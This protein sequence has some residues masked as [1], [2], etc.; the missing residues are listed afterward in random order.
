MALYIMTTKAVL[1]IAKVHQAASM[2]HIE[3]RLNSKGL[4]I[5][6]DEPQEEAGFYPRVQ[7][8]GMRYMML[9]LTD[10]VPGHRYAY[11]HAELLHTLLHSFAEYF[12]F[13]IATAGPM[14]EESVPPELRS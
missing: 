12:D 11:H 5:R 4:L 8:G 2:G 3:W 1:L 9:P 14:A 7:G 10:A 6:R 13:A